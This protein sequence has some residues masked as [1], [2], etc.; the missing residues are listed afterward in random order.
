MGTQRAHTIHIPPIE[1]GSDSSSYLRVAYLRISAQI[2]DTIC[3]LNVLQPL[4]R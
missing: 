2:Y 4:V 1:S 3:V